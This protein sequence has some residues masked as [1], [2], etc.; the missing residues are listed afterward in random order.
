MADHEVIEDGMAELVVQSAAEHERYVL[1]LYV[2]GVSPRSV[3]AIQ[4]AR[5]LCEEHL[6]GRCELEVIDIYQ[7]PVLARSAQLVAAP[8]LVKE[9]PLPL[10]RFVGTLSDLGR[11]LAAL[12]IE[13][14]PA[15]PETT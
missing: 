5:R 2:T 14:V 7:H 4:N 1:R 12:G 13:P 10:R 11:I 3:W 8:T 9:L 6:L 15:P